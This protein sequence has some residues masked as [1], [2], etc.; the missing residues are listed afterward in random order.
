[1]KRGDSGLSL[2][3]GVDKPL[4]MTSHDVVNR[5][6]RIFGERRVGHAGTLD[7]LASGVMVVCV[8]P[9]TRL[10]PYLMSQEKEYEA[11]IQFGYSTDTDD[12][13]GAVL[14]QGAI[15][16]ELWDETYAQEVL[17]TFLGESKQLP[18]AYSAIKVQGVK[19][20]E[21]ARKGTVISLVP[22]DITVSKAELL[23]IESTNDQQPVWIVDFVVSKG[24]YIR[25]LARDIGKACNTEAHL[26]GLRRTV[27]GHLA[28]DRC[29]SLETLEA[30]KE[31]AALDPV[32]LLGT[33]FAFIDDELAE[34]VAH[35]N[36]L[37]SADL[38]LFH[39]LPGQWQDWS[40]ACV[41]NLCESKD[42]L[43]NEEIIAL[44]A[45]NKLVALYG[46]DEKKHILKARCVF[47]QGVIRDGD[48]LA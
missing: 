37:R 34:R 3:V 6:R 1:M 44:I 30:I 29:V 22:R 20:Y 26:S 23:A 7:P 16:P 9:A 5:C 27:S 8:G 45:H 17:N 25:S 18:P 47:P 41:P 10:D 35:G 31:K 28:L 38:T 2:V 11:R 32:T 15:Y 43:Q 46:Y 33:R 4:G 48:L 19:S 21:A 13:E 36:Q 42:P 12:G 40:C 39:F 24:T 14:R